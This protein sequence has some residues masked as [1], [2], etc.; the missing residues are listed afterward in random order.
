MLVRE[1]ITMVGRAWLRKALAS[2]RLSI[3]HAKVFSRAVGHDNDSDERVADV[4]C[5]P[6]SMSFWK[7]RSNSGLA[8]C[9]EKDGMPLLVPRSHPATQNMHIGEVMFGE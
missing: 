9:V 2:L 3:T 4:A 5:A 1:L 6:K 7:N 8:G